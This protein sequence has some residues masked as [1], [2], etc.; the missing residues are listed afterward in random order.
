MIQTS[1]EI[2][3]CFWLKDSE[4]VAWLEQPKDS[5]TTRIVAACWRNPADRHVVTEI[6]SRV[7]GFK[8]VDFEDGRLG[9]VVSALQTPTGD[10]YNG[11]DSSDSKDET[12]SSVR[13]YDTIPERAFDSWLTVNKLSLW[14]GILME[15]ADQYSM[16][17]S[18]TNLLKGSG[19]H[20]SRAGTPLGMVD[21]YDV[22]RHGLAFC[23]DDRTTPKSE[24][25]RSCLFY[26]S[27]VEW[28]EGRPGVFQKVDGTVPEHGVCASVNFSSD[29][30][31]L[32]FIKDSPIPDSVPHV[33]TVADVTQS[34][35]ATDTFVG[36]DGDSLWDACPTNVSWGADGKSLLLRSFEEGREKL[37]YAQIQGHDHIQ[38]PCAIVNEGSV[39]SSTVLSNGL[40]FATSSNFVDDSV[41]TIVD[42]TVQRPNNIQWT[43]SKS[44]NGQLF[45]L[46]PGQI[47]EF[48]YESDNG[49]LIHSW[50]IKPSTFDVSKKYPLLIMVHGGPQ[51]AWNN[52]WFTRSNAAIF[53]E[54]GFIVML[55][56]ITGSI[57]WGL[58]LMKSVLGDSGGAPLLDLIAGFDHVEKH[59]PFV[60]TANAVLEGAS[61]GGYMA[62]WIQGQDFG[63]KFKALVTYV[64]CPSFCITPCNSRSTVTHTLSI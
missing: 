51:W 40:V 35:I 59:Y 50:L 5:H 12:K 3:E 52:T 49:R 54:A 62:N 4:V 27:W 6:Q 39:E 14:L 21:Y 16:A 22:G 34:L 57:G 60:D 26:S 29:G 25:P 8:L 61:Y 23:S 1:T 37:F 46:S 42:P 41:Y 28:K 18:L 7:S 33:L 15:R 11:N 38:L 58:E 31:K 47:S 30:A 10:L 24:N 45:E 43:S 13:T 36:S 56:N 53:A 17:D 19:L 32:A 64:V 20:L 9:F 44:K 55:P 2:T 63:R 48:Y